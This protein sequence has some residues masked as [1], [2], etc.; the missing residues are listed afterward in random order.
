MFFCGYDGSGNLFV[1][2]YSGQH[3]GLAELAAGGAAFSAISVDRTINVPGQ[4]QWDGNYITVEDAYQPVIYQFA[5]L[6]SSGT[7]VGI[8]R[9][10]Q[11]GRRAAESWIGAGI[12]AVPTGPNAKRAIEIG[13]WPYPS[14]GKPLSFI[15]GFVGN[16]KEITG[17]AMSILP[18]GR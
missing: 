17:V 10:H 5:I 15:K 9:F 18:S 7:T 8:T 4:V 2:G 14:G 16:H 3:F 13:I 1:D 6:L 11:I 12:V